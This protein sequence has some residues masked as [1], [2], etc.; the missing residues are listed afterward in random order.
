MTP[1]GLFVIVASVAGVAGICYWIW[2][3][4]HTILHPPLPAKSPIPSPLQLPQLSQNGNSQEGPSIGDTEER[5]QQ[6]QIG[7]QQRKQALVKQ[8]AQSDRDLGKKLMQCA[9]V[10]RGEYLDSNDA[11]LV[12]DVARRI[13]DLELLVLSLATRTLLD[14]DVQ[15]RSDRIAVNYPTSDIEPQAMTDIAQFPDMLPEQLMAEDD[16]FY[17]KIVLNEA[18]VMQSFERFEIDK[19]LYTLFDVSGSMKEL[20]ESGLP[21]HIVARAIMIKLLYRAINGQAK[22][23][24]RDFDGE[25]HELQLALTPDEAERLSDLILHGGLTNGGT[26]IPRALQRAIGDI[27]QQQAGIQEAE[28]LLVSDG[29]D[30]KIG[31]PDQLRSL[32]GSDIRLHVALVGKHSAI[33]QAVAHT[34]IHFP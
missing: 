2:K 20:V 22:Y 28:I 31:D 8:V 23:Y 5:K 6:E 30:E 21:R 12:A 4:V 3:K 27:R 7:Q 26:N 24:H 11:Q 19:I 13:G 33:L 14:I 15:R 9:G 29:E 17:R 1:L 18:V 16:E 25:P 10:S 32:L 34:Y